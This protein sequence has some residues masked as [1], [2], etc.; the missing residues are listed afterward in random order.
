M[1]LQRLKALDVG[2]LHC[3][4]EHRAALTVPNV[5]VCPMSGW[6]KVEVTIPEYK[7][8]LLA[9]V[10]AVFHVFLSVAI[11]QTHFSSVFIH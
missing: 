8:A 3:P 10:L 11:S 4:V 6:D 7:V 9:P 2:A 1:A 5:D